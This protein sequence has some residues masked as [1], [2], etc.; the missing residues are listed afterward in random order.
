M[1]IKND[2]MAPNFKSQIEQA[3]SIAN[4]HVAIAEF[5]DNSLD[6]EATKIKVT[7][8]VG[9]QNFDLYV[10]DNGTGMTPEKL[11]SAMRLGS[12][13]KDN[14]NRK[15]LGCKGAGKK[16]ASSYL[17]GN[18]LEVYTKSKSCD[19][20]SYS[21]FD[22][23]DMESRPRDNNWDSLY[24]FNSVDVEQ[25]ENT[26][27]YNWLQDIKSGTVVICGGMKKRVCKGKTVFD[28]KVLSQKERGIAQTYRH[29]LND[30]DLELF[31]NANQINALG[32]G[33]D[34]KEGKY[35][36]KIFFEDRY[37]GGWISQ[38]V[39]PWGTETYECRFRFIRIATKDSLG[40]SAQSGGL[41]VFRNSREVTSQ[42][43]TG[44]RPADFRIGN[45]VIELDC[46][47]SFLDKALTFNND[48]QI[49]TLENATE[50]FDFKTY[51]KNLW[52]NKTGG[53]YWNKIIETNQEDAITGGSGSE[54]AKSWRYDE[55]AL[56]ERFY[57]SRYESMAAF[58]YS[59]EELEDVLIQEYEIPGTRFRI[60][61]V[62]NGVPYEF[63]VRSDDVSKIVGQILSYIPYLIEDKK[64]NFV[65]NNKVRFILMLG[66]T[67]TKSLQRHVE[68]INSSVSFDDIG[69]EIKIVDMT[70]KFPSLISYGMTRREKIEN[71]ERQA[72]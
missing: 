67:P 15:K 10:M 23:E 18:K 30:T 63:K 50:N 70:L 5:I 56:V 46:P 33:F 58:E 45:L 47:S 3:K 32:P 16:L 60:D 55:T 40:T 6:A 43:I 39:C 25:I 19:K 69:V 62:D 20:I 1:T 48:K 38:K 72:A 53:N 37:K 42:L 24:K 11:N 64:F 13:T 29:I 22:I 49:R 26:I 54:K 4:V 31:Y 59:T 36:D 68:R 8:S 52:G 28:K 17:A 14:A 65:K 41:S 27:I 34:H 7:S 44:I 9:D 57:K 35:Q 2:G 21:C 51:W 66:S 61:M 71:K 12:S